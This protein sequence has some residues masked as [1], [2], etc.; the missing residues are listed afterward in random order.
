LILTFFFY[1]AY[2]LQDLG[3]DTVTANLML[4][5]PADAR[6]YDIAVAMLKD[7]GCTECRLLTNNPD[8]IEQLERGGV[9]RVVERV[10][11]IPERWQ[12]ADV[13]NTSTFDSVNS[14]P[15]ECYTP[16]EMDSYLFTKIERMRHLLDLPR[17][18]AAA[19]STASLTPVSSSDVSC[20]SSMHQD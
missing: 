6:N 18:V 12:L 17:S 8:K 3:H 11:M 15:R 9:V 2:N 20:T 4:S 13:E 7:L 14:T 16:N 1:R 5:H 10:P 19:L